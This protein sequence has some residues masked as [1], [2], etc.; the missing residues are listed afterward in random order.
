MLSSFLSMSAFLRNGFRWHFLLVFD[1]FW[2]GYTDI[3][4]IFLLTYNML[5]AILNHNELNR[6]DRLKSH[7]SVGADLFL[8]RSSNDF[9]L[10][11]NRSHTLHDELILISGLF[12]WSTFLGWKFLKKVYVPW[13]RTVLKFLQS[14]ILKTVCHGKSETDVKEKSGYPKSRSW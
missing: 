2:D 12:I 3:G 10:V 7:C 5:Y 1:S 13:W 8:K 11:Q 9:Y 14:S 4:D 6:N